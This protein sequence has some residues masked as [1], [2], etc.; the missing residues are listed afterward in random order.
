MSLYGNKAKINGIPCGLITWG[1]RNGEYVVYF[2]RKYASLEQIEAI[3]WRRP[4]LD[5]PC[6]M[7]AGYGF[8]VKNIEYHMSERSWVVT[9]KVREQ[10]LGDVTGYQAQIDA[11][12]EDKARLEADGA[13]KDT[14][15]KG[16]KDQLAEADETAI[17]LF[18]ELEAARAE[19]AATEAAAPA[20]S[21]PE[22]EEVEA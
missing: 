15:I 9:L 17:A 6:E 1:N 12:E 16:L 2:E 19:A 20:E 14:A 4:K 10:Y 8:D 18:E 21:A 7:P 5:G 22:S 11:L 3:N 13:D